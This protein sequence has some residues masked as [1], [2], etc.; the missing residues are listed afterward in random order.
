M[1][2]Q[3]SHKNGTLPQYQFS[4]LFFLIIVT[5]YLSRTT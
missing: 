4:V 3:V 2:Y 1:N 5:K